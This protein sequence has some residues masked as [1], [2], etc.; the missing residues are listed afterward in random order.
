MLGLWCYFHFTASFE[1]FSLEMHCVILKE[2]NTSTYKGKRLAFSHNDPTI[3][4]MFVINL[5][6]KNYS[7]A[8]IKT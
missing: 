7:L 2:I 8:L 4:A 1:Q 5:R 3:L 6:F